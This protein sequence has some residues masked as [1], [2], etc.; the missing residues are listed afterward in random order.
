MKTIEL[1]DH[2]ARIVVAALDLYIR[3]GLGQIWAVPEALV[4]L[5]PAKQFNVWELREKYTDAIQLELFDFSP[6][7]SYGITHALVAD[8]TKIAFDLEQTIKGRQSLHLGSE[9]IPKVVST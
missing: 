9:P 5:H 8:R 6:T 3:L 2:Q 1:T 4:E 7:A